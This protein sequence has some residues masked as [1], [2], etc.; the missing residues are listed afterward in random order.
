MVSSPKRDLEI[1]RVLVAEGHIVAEKMQVAVQSKR[2]DKVNS[3][4]STRRADRTG[5][6][7]I[8]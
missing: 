4:L 2:V 7:S 6:R 5:S 8:L 3:N 1:I